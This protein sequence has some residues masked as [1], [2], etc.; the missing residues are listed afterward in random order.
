M[1]PIAGLLVFLKQYIVNTLAGPQTVPW[2]EMADS[3][4][5]DDD[6]DDKE[7]VRRRRIS[8]FIPLN[9][10]FQEEKKSLKERLQ[11]IQEVT[12]SVQNAIGRLASLG[13]AVKK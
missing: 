8:I 2:D 13:E 5:E 11:A 9:D 4:L 12:Q 10:L 3:D 7:K 6:D 1:I